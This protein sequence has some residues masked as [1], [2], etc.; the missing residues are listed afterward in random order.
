[1]LALTAFLMAHALAAAPGERW[2]VASP[3]DSVRHA[4]PGRVIRAA[5]IAMP[6]R[7]AISQE[8]SEVAARFAADSLGA[9]WPVWLSTIAHRDCEPYRAGSEDPGEDVYWVFRCRVPW[10]FGRLE[11]ESFLLERDSIPT[12]ERARW[13]AGASSGL[14]RSHADTLARHLGAALKENVRFVRQEAVTGWIG[15]WMLVA[16]FPTSWGQLRLYQ[17]AA[18]DLELRDSLILEHTSRRLAEALDRV[19][20]QGSPYGWDPWAPDTVGP[21]RG[22]AEAAQALET[23]SPGLSRALRITPSR[24]EDVDVVTDAIT[25]ARGESASARSDAVLW[26]AHLW[27]TGLPAPTDTATSRRLASRLESHGIHRVPLPDNDWCWEDSIPERLAR[28]ADEDLWTDR[29]FLE[30]MRRGW[31]SGCALCG[32]EEP[33][34]PD[35]F[36]PTIARGEGFLRRHPLSP[37]ARETR[38]LIAVAHET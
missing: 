23:A 25:A 13:S 28:R 19:E 34:G 38:W 36:L 3:A 5:L 35:Q 11:T 24:P 1:M 12:V 26:G 37:V 4:T 16:E 17:G 14:R 32:S 9:Q 10:A 33:Y 6:E 15:P 8:L 29:A 27:V 7:P 30:L 22:R 20:S 18:S 2:I 21:A 31:E